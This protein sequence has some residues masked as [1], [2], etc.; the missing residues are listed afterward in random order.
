MLQTPGNILQNLVSPPLA[1]HPAPDFTLKTW[2]GA[3]N[4]E[5]QFASLRG[6]CVVINFWASW[7]DA[8]KVEAPDFEATWQRYRTRNV[9]FIGVAFDD[10]T[11]NSLNFLR[12]YHISYII[13]PD[14]T[15][16][17]A[18][19]YQVTNTGVPETVFINSR[20]VVVNKLL[21]AIDAGTL[22]HGIQVKLA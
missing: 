2:N 13:G 15:G 10:T 6:K 20:G 1:G 7:C 16:T 21:G 12:Q 9:V 19:A 17:I 8:C 3:S 14:T 18:N 22:E 4:H 11:T 5:V